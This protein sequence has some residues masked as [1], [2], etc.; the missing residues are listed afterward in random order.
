MISQILLLG[1]LN[2]P[3]ILLF[4]GCV[5]VVAYLVARNNQAKGLPFWRTFI[6][7]MIGLGGLGLLLVN[8][9]GYLVD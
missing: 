9:F 2:L 8:I 6:M 3:R 7:A 4:A 1:G 5:I